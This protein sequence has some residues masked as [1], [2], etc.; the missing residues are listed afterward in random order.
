VLVGRS[1]SVQPK[2]GEEVAAAVLLNGTCDLARLQMFC[3]QHLADFKVPGTIRF[4]SMLPKYSIGPAFGIRFSAP[5]KAASTP[6]RPYSSHP[7]VLTDNKE[8]R[9]VRTAQKFTI[10]EW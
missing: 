1:I 5:T 2:Y 9:R 6:R 10:A 7:A 3:R 4:L 8:V